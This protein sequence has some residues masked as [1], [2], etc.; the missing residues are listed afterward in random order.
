VPC[1]VCK[2][3]AQQVKFERVSRFSRD[4]DLNLADIVKES[5]YLLYLKHFFSMGN[6]IQ[7]YLRDVNLLLMYDANA[8]AFGRL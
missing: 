8:S 1:I 3:V 5:K 4:L 2:Y 6:W 7:I